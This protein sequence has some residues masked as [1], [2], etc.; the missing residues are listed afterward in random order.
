MLW[1]LRFLSPFPYFL[2]ATDGHTHGGP[3]AGDG[4]LAGSAGLQRSQAPP[5]RPPLRRPHHHL[6]LPGT[7][8]RRH[9]A[10]RTVS[11]TLPLQLRGGRGRAAERPGLALPILS[12]LQEA[13]PRQGAAPTGSAAADTRAAARGRRPALPHREDG[14]MAAP[15][16]AGLHRR[17]ASGSVQ[18]GQ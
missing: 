8:L 17:R 7:S 10:V 14:A 3:P 12:A 5:G 13:P 1:A 4:D 9:G 16:S 15:H 6:H 2:T 11:R 18:D